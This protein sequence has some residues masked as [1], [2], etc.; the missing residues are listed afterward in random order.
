M[1]VGHSKTL[2]NVRLKKYKRTFTGATELK[3]TPELLKNILG[4]MQD[5]QKLIEP[6]TKCNT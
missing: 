4:G 5:L 1:Y 2:W 6:L 3:I